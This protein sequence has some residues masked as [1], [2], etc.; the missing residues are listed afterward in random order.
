MWLFFF[1][2]VCLLPWKETPARV[3]ELPCCAPQD[4]ETSSKGSTQRYDVGPGR[5]FQPPL[6]SALTWGAAGLWFHPA[7]TCVGKEKG[8][9][10][11]GLLVQK[12]TPCSGHFF[13]VGGATLGKLAEDGESFLQTSA[14]RRSEITSWE[15]KGLSGNAL[16]LPAQPG[17]TVSH[18]DPKRDQPHAHGSVQGCNFLCGSCH[19]PYVF[20]VKLSH[21][22]GLSTTCHSR[23]G[24]SDPPE[25]P[26]CVFRLLDSWEIAP[27]THNFG[28]WMALWL[29]SGD[30]PRGLLK[31]HPMS[32]CHPL[33][34]HPRVTPQSAP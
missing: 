17:T 10:W 13:G 20:V 4:Q 21:W 33:V 11:D 29:L 28:S 1:L 9:V 5:F 26:S 34:L 3:S 32:P 8:L 18:L 25:S 7:G 6:L 22:P 2:L 16:S 15:R 24:P 30:F 19:L 14:Q 12:R 23:D 31:I 27:E